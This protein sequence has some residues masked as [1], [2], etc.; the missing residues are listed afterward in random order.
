ME[1]LFI[2]LMLVSLVCFLLSWLIPNT[3]SPLFKN[4]LSKGW[5]RLVFGIASIAFFVM[6]GMATDSNKQTQSNTNEKVAEQKFETKQSSPEEQAKKAEADAE[7]KKKAEEEKV[8]KEAEEA[9]K[10][11]K[12]STMKGDL[13][14]INFSGEVKPLI[15]SSGNKV[16]IKIDIENL[17][18]KV[19]IDDVRLL[20]SDKSFISEG[21]T[22]V[23]IM[24]GGQ[25]DTDRS[26][27]WKG[28]PLI[29]IPPKEKRSF[30]IV[31]QAKT[32]GNYKSVIS[33]KS[34]SKVFSNPQGNE[35]LVAGLTVLQ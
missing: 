16:V 22:I 7:A 17:S 32:P 15:A 5:I 3:F 1:N 33:I 12:T 9:Q 26:F 4:K 28:V 10:E 18:D 11:L 34:N 14:K 20:F 29:E 6:F 30:Q 19:T 2:I 8:K 21:L 31:A 35:E 24:N 13:P 25:Q 23:N 27:L